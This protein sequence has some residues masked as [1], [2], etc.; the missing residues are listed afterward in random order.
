MDKT[1][2]NLVGGAMVALA[3]LGANKDAVAGDNMV[4]TKVKYN[5][6]TEQAN[7]QVYGLL[8]NGSAWLG[9]TTPLNENAKDAANT[10]VEFTMT[11]KSSAA[12][13]VIEKH[14][15]P[16]NAYIS[17]QG[18]GSGVGF[19]A[20]WVT[21]KVGGDNFG[22][23]GNAWAVYYP[24]LGSDNHDMVFTQI[25]VKPDVKKSKDDGAL[26]FAAKYVVPDNIK[27]NIVNALGEINIS[28]IELTW[29]QKAIKDKLSSLGTAGKAGQT[30]IPNAVLGSVDKE[31]KLK[32]VGVEYNTG[33]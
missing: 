17:A 12:E 31:G 15:L 20:Q 32:N 8:N 14:L 1:L 5:V 33:F 18:D 9:V 11:T 25:N 2:K 7:A 3:V 4:G 13:N 30:I 27:T 6:Q 23:S 21:P 28:E 19:G 26:S 22:I 29:S 16:Q 10:L 24:K